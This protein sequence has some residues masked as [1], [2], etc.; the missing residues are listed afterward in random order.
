MKERFNKAAAELRTSAVEELKTKKASVRGTKRS[1]TGLAEG[2]IHVRGDGDRVKDKWVHTATG[3]TS[4]TKVYSGEEAEK[5]T[6]R[7]KREK[8]G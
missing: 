4:F 2:W 5:R 3:A 8:T 1:S 6:T 7:R